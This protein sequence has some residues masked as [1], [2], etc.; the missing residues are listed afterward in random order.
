MFQAID[1]GIVIARED[2]PL[3][4][5]VFGQVDNG[6]KHQSIGTGLGLPLARALTEL[7][8][9]T[10]DLQSAVGRGTTVTLRLPAHRVLAPAR[11]VTQACASYI[12]APLTAGPNDAGSQIGT[13]LRPDTSKPGPPGRS[14]PNPT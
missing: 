9:G 13:A 8:G 7:H 1:T 5:S 4:L 6:T 11:T 3:A 2:I 10:L 12:R 14:A